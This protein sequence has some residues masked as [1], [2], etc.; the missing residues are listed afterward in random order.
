MSSIS[1]RAKLNLALHVTGQKP[2]GAPQAG[3]HTLHSLVAFADFGDEVSVAPSDQDQLTVDG[4]FAAGVPALSKNTLGKAL[5]M[6]RDWSEDVL[7]AEPVSISLTKNLP[8]ASG[9][10]GGSADAAALI[11][12]LTKGRALGT[13]EAADV[14]KLGADVPMCL[15][16]RSAIISGI[17][18]EIMPIALPKCALV[19]VNPGVAMETPDVFRMLSKKTNPALPDLPKL[20]DLASLVSYLEGTRNDLMQPAISLAP[21]IQQCLDSLSGAPFSRMSGSGATCFALLE[22]PEEAE[23]VAAEAQKTHPDW[24]VREGLLSV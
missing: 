13:D 23:K 21:V 10:G 8:V 5:A 15:N 12:L 1:A 3:Y 4:P 7:A 11:A 6:V 9:I 16:G 14:L 2:A 24:W 22:T 18:E 19:L 20:T 17:G